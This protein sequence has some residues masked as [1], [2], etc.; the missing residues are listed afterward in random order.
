MGRIAR[1]AI[2]FVVIAAAAFFGSAL[3][4][5][6]PADVP[7]APVQKRTGFGVITGFARTPEGRP[8][9]GVVVSLDSTDLRLKSSMTFHRTGPP[10]PAF[11]D[12]VDGRFHA[13]TDATGAYRASRLIDGVT[14]RLVAW[15]KGFEVHPVDTQAAED[16][17]DGDRVDFE[18]RKAYQVVLRVIGPD[19]AE[20][21]AAQV[22]TAVDS[23]GYPRGA[24][25]AAWRR[26][27][28]IELIAGSVDI[29]ATVGRSLIGSA[30]LMLPPP[31]GESAEVEIRLAEVTAVRVTVV[32]ADLVQIDGVEVVA[33]KGMVDETAV[34]KG[35]APAIATARVS[36]SMTHAEFSGLTPGIHTF[37]ARRDTATLAVATL[38]V[39]LGINYQKLAIPAESVADFVVVHVFDPAGKRLRAAVVD[40]VSGVRAREREKGV[41][42]LPRA[43]VQGAAASTPEASIYCVDGG[44]LGLIV[45]EYS[46]KDDADRIVRFEASRTLNVKLERY[47]GTAVENRLDLVVRPIVDSTLWNRHADAVRHGDDPR[48]CEV[49]PSGVWTFKGLQPG[50]YEV[51]VR[52]KAECLK[53]VTLAA[54]T[55]EL[56]ASTNDCVIALPDLARLVVTS[57]QAPADL[58]IVLVHDSPN[59]SQR[60]MPLPERDAAG[61]FVFD[62]IPV[63]AYKLSGRQGD[64]IFRASEIAVK[65]DATVVYDLLPERD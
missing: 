19:G 39:A 30:K 42:W 41:Y 9:E 8:V 31:S 1:I 24:Y 49:D 48:S 58:Q 40:C 22:T 5:E 60:L 27:D 50:A 54:S 38:D 12:D 4:F 35:E 32:C 34:R 44:D 6:K 45:R 26:G 62:A 51:E 47:R 21:D 10:A 36:A 59:G 7:G 53:G 3:V 65:G 57:P 20:V 18:V 2:V 63:G 29:L 64:R 37:C 56:E 28:P 15:K 25:N 46:P 17:K 55:A 61:R 16:A 43:N 11:A 23:P 33:F 13:K 14:Y 52:G